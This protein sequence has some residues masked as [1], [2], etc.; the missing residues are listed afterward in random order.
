MGVKHKRLNI[1]LAL[2]LE[3]LDTFNG[4]HTGNDYEGF[5]LKIEDKR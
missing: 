5:L 2:V 4:G 1:T 3:R